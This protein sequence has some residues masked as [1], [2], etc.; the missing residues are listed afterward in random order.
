M[1]GEH[2]STVRQQMV[3][4]PHSCPHA[5]EMNAC[6]LEQ[7]RWICVNLVS[8]AHRGDLVVVRVL[9]LGPAGLLGVRNVLAQ[10]RLRQ[11]VGIAGARLLCRSTRPR[12]T[13]SLVRISAAKRR[14]QS[15]AD[16][17]R[18]K[19]KPT[20]KQGTCGLSNMRRCSFEVAWFTAG[21][22]GACLGVLCLV[23]MAPPV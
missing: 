13:R 18:D 9:Q 3:C 20:T 14:R 17:D 21:Q 6:K 5:S 16:A 19:T 15:C 12:Q 1:N 2:A 22:A 7:C 11:D 10:H 8:G 23:R 4:A